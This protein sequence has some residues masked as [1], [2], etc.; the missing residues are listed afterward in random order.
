[1]SLLRAPTAWNLR[2]TPQPTMERVRSL[3]TP[4]LALFFAVFLSR[5]FH[6]NNTMFPKVHKPKK[7]IYLDYAAATPLDA[8]VF[9]HMKPY[10][11]EKF[12]NPSS[13]YINGREA[14]EAIEASRQTIAGALNARASE[15]IFTSGGTES[16][17]LA[18]FGIARGF[19]GKGHLIASAI[20]HHSVINSFKALAE[21]GRKVTFVKVGDE[22]IIDLDKLKSSVRP[23]TILISVM[24]AN[25]EIGTIEPVAEI[26]HWLRGENRKRFAK[27]QPKILLHTDACQAAG[28]L[29]LDVNGLGVDLMSANGGKIYGPKGIGFLYVRS[30]IHLKPLIYGGGQE[31]DMRGGTENVAGIVGLAKA[32]EIAD[33]NR[34]KE[35]KR[36]AGLRN[37]LK[38]AILAKVPKMLLNGP[39]DDGRL[40][41][42]LNLTVRGIEG[43]ALMLYLDSYGVCV[44]TASACS[45]GTTEVS[46]VLLA[47]G[48]TEKEAKSG[49][50]ITLGRQTT[51]AELDYLIKILPPIVD[52]LR[53]M[54]SM[55]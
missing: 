19:K 7:T 3:C 11:S 4:S 24:L 49:I 55:D 18:I 28:F 8:Q 52:E 5:F 15:I 36:L 27:H 2:S 22:G 12:G 32:L 20:E 1:L 50:R 47:I 53:K 51:K 30:G 25:N 39:A 38:K 10:L 33:I 23:E 17:N 35:S 45:T 48:R 44:S 37:Y 46:H 43:E 54:K 14:K 34:V 9:K 41:N 16:V 21:E 40:P 42:N 6:Y 29:D 26:A 31:H 13:L